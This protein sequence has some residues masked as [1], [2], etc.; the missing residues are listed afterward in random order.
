[1]LDVMWKQRRRYHYNYL[2]LCLAGF[3]IERKKANCYYCSEF[4]GEILQRSCVEGVERLH[5]IIQPIHFLELPYTEIYCGKL[6]EY[7]YIK[8]KIAN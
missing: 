3:H 7:A 2:G 8:G 4:V 1:M 5:S 6:N